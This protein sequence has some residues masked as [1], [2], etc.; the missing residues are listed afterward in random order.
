[1]IPTSLHFTSLHFTDFQSCLLLVFVV[2][3]LLACCFNA[4]EKFRLSLLFLGLASVTIFSFAITLDPFLNLWDERFHALVAKNL[5]NHPLMPTLYDDPVVDMAYDRWDRYH[6]WLHKQPLFL[7][8]IA[9]SFKI[10]GISEF[11]LRLPLV[12]L[13]TVLVLIGYRT[14]RLVVNRNAGFYTAILIMTNFYLIE[15]ISGR[16]ELEHNDFSF[17]VYISLSIWAFVEYYFSGKRYWIPVIGLFSGLAIL[18]K[19]LPGLLVYSGWFVLKIMNKQYKPKLYTDLIAALIVTIMIAAPWQILSF[20][21][22]PAEA[23][24]T[25]QLNYDHFTRVLDGHH[26]DL[27]YHVR[28]FS[29]IYGSLSA[30]LIIP[31]WFVLF[32]QNRNR[33]L[34]IALASM[35]LI[36]YIF[37]TFTRT[38]MPSFTILPLLIIMIAFGALFDR[39]MEYLTG[40]LPGTWMRRVVVI[41]MVLGFAILSLNISTISDKHSIPN[42]HN[43]YASMLLHNK[44]VFT[45]MDVPEYAVIFNVKGRHYI[46]CMFY[47]GRPAYN[48]I[49]SQVQVDQLQSRN[50]SVVVFKPLQDELPSYLLNDSTII[51][52]NDTIQ[53]YD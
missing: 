48:F 39:I 43:E 36:T 32:R 49:P 45:S 9:L 25:Y 41:T 10:F 40:F 37:F 15:L 3:F 27:W 47:T 21:W 23:A 4:L 42:E 18:C 20:I 6:I 24:Q 8:Q 29:T 34:L 28:Q 51:I 17:L 1:M 44:Q 38:K 5:M 50:R 30:F 22:Y 53:G 46:E 11:T 33:D 13:A 12:A 2:F 35:V 26:G 19:W 14:A 7:W 16:Q 31:A 52:L